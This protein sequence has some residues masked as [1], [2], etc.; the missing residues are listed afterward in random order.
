MMVQI[1]L[2]FTRI[3]TVY[4][5]AIDL[6]ETTIRR[7]LTPICNRNIYIVCNVTKC[8]NVT[9]WYLEHDNNLTH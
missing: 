9:A 8:S 7:G 5:E 6:G 4:G 3:K 1:S 2:Q